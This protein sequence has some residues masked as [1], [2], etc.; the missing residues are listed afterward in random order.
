MTCNTICK[1]DICISHTHTYTKQLPMVKTVTLRVGLCTRE[2]F[3][4]ER[5]RVEGVLLYTRSFQNHPPSNSTPYAT[6]HE[7]AM[8]RV[9]DGKYTMV[10]VRNCEI[11]IK[12]ASKTRNVRIQGNTVF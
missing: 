1:I 10:G 6:G 5:E 12:F 9:G 8:W 4:K 2:G 7:L 11:S 3:A